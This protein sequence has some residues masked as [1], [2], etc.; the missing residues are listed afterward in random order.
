MK[1]SRIHRG[2]NLWKTIKMDFVLLY[3]ALFHAKTPWKV[4]I[5]IILLV[6]YIVSPLDLIPGWI[7]GLG[8][9]DDIGIAVLVV[10]WIKKMIPERLQEEIEGKI[11]H[12]K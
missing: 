3:R 7:V 12:G 10:G 2:R 6:A 5:L 8:L 1:A 9:L 4:R 11:I